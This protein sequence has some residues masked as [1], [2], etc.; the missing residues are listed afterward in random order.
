MSI[1][2]RSQTVTASTVTAPVYEGYGVEVNGDILAIQESWEDQIAVIEALHSLDMEELALRS[3]VKTLQESS[4]SQSEIDARFERYETVTE[5]MVGDAWTK[6]KEFFA[7]L[8]GKIKAFFKSVVRVFDGI[9][10]SAESFVKKYKSD[11]KKLNLRDYKYKMFNYTHIDDDLGSLEEVKTMADELY[12]EATKASVSGYTEVAL[13]NLDAKINKMR[14]NKEDML[15]VIRGEMVEKGSLSPEQY[16][17]E[18]FAMFR[19]GAKSKEDREEISVNIDAI[20]TA[21]EKAGDAKKKADEFG[22]KLD[23]EFSR[24]IKD[25]DALASKVKGAKAEGNH[26]DVDLGEGKGGKRKVKSD[27]VTKV[28]DALRL[29][30]GLYSSTKSIQLQAFR[31]WQDAWKERNTVYKTVCTG[32][33]RHK[34]EK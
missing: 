10:R 24:I 15:D 23:S 30:S 17:H 7:K 16:A 19:G 5:S 31:A 22:K 13:T 32:A 9:F 14:E 11:L 34:A 20:I 3:D 2:G 26:V 6:I 12:A 25:I 1:F 8:W 18:L 27:G 29:Y 33:F 21:I 4:S 28:V